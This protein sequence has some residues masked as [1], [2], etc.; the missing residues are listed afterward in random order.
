[1]NIGLTL[2]GGAIRGIIHLGVIK[3]LEENGIKPNIIA[4]T[5]MGSIIGGLYSCGLSYADILNIVKE[6][7][8]Q[9]YDINWKGITKNIFSKR[10]PDGIVKG[11][12]IEKL[13]ED[14]THGINIK[15]VNNK[16]GIVATN[17]NGGENVVFSNYN[18]TGNNIICINDVQLSK[19]IRASISLPFIFKPVILD[20][21][22]LVDGGIVNN[23]PV[24][25]AQK[26]GA[27]YIIVS[28]ID[29]GGTSTGTNLTGM[30]VLLATL[31]I[32]VK[33]ACEDYFEES[34]IPRLVINFGDIPSV[35]MFDFT[36][37]DINNL[38]NIG[39]T[40]ANHAIGFLEKKLK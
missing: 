37:E 24:N 2:S 4:G 40:R 27:E 19:A 25:I 6:I 26:L 8:P 36:D 11:E 34:T 20:N 14:V 29:Y 38:F 23:C 33:E 31:D 32:I 16:L 9:I 1:M 30:D 17:L 28:D 21:Y 7:T 12:K 3:A 10:L 13:I 5:S 39:Y 22:V 18:I 15:D 35:S